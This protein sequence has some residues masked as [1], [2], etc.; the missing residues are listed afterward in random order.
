[1]TDAPQGRPRKWWVATAPLNQGGH[2]VTGPFETR[3]VALH[4][5]KFAQIVH[6]PASLVVVEESD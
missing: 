5:L 2:K 3:E 1:M 4:A 6:K